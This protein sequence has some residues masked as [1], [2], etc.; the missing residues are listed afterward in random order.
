[1]KAL[2]T[3][4]TG[5]IGGALA[6]R[7][8]GAGWQVTGLGRN[9]TAL[10]ELESAGIATRRCD[11]ADQAAAIDVCREQEVVFH[12]AAHA[13]DWGSPND[14]VLNNVVA[15]RNIIAGCQQHAVR[16]LVHVSTP[17]LYF[18]FR[19]RLNVR[20]DDPLPPPMN[21]Y[22]RTKRMAEDEVN[23]ACR[24]GL[25]SVT[26]RPSAVFGPGD[27]ILLPR[28]LD[29]LERRVL[30]II[31]DGGAI[32]DLTYV[33]NVV[34]ALILCA[35][36]RPTAIGKVYNITNGEPVRIWDL[37]RRI[38][39]RLDLAE[40]SFRVPYRVADAGAALIE[41]AWRVTQ[42]AGEPPVTRYSVSRIG[43]SSS[44]DIS[45]ARAE[46]GYEPRVP[47]QTAIDCTLEE[48]QRSRKV[49]GAART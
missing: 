37:V 28:L 18:H 42:R 6:R 5:F 38:C 31:G 22:A 41:G 25:P 23:R 13:S 14:F 21:D 2:V 4:A 46:L 33:E 43:L 26:I 35:D 1:M 17:S 34:D 7:L 44:L 10:A 27:R 19:E 24:E 11:L 32:V 36:A 8:H 40:P 16:R 29:R 12:S 15:T 39:K 45:A 47:L 48:W 20:E 30:P 9:T 49:G 3:G